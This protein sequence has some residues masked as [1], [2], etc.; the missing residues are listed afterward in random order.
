MKNHAKALGLTL[1]ALVV[2]MAAALFGILSA[3]AQ[4]KPVNPLCTATAETALNNYWQTQVANATPATMT[5]VLS[6][7]ITATSARVKLCEGK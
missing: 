6:A 1:T 5:R 3:R 7:A 2:I 4:T